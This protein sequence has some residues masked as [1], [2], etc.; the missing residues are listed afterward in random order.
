MTNKLSDDYIREAAYFMWENDGRPETDGTEYW[1]K[2]MSQL[3]STCSK[4]SCS[5]K[6]AS[7]STTAKKTVK[8]ATSKVAKP[9]L[10]F[11]S[12]LGKK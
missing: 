8:K 11:A 6:K 3:S 1:F 9:A 5:A 4:S 7:A 2:A 10:K 12:K